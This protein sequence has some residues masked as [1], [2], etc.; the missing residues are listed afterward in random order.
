MTTE[1]QRENERGSKGKGR[2]RMAM[3]RQR[4]LGIDCAG[5]DRADTD[6]TA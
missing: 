4:G 1:G 5:Q 3:E 2:V 6:K